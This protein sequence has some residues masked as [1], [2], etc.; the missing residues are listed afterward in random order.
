MRFNKQISDGSGSEF[1]EFG[2]GRAFERSGRAGSSFLTNFSARV[3][4]GFTSLRAGS[5]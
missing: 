3:G 4:P 1:V 5:G 2:P